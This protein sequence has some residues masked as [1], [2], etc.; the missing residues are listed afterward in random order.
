MRYMLD[1]DTTSYIMKKNTP[2]HKNV[3]R[4]VKQHRPEDIFI[5]SLTVSEIALGMFKLKNR[6]PEKHQLL[7][8][9]TIRIMVAMNVK[10][11]TGIT[12]WMYGDIRAALQEA[13]E[14]I[15]VMDCLIAAHAIAEEM[16]LVTNNLRH[17]MRI[18]RL[19]IENWSS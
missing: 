14:D 6:H 8:D 13:G 17:F 5:S 2:Q 19:K 16:V 12:A 15:G 4:M 18:P 9:H 3:L 11:F 10:N 1:T 7:Y